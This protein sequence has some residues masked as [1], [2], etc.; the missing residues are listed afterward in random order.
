MQNPAR[1]RHYAILEAPAI[2]GLRSTGVER[3]PEVLLKC[4]LAERLR[5]RRVGAVAPDMPRCPDRDPEAN[6]LNARA[7]A[8]YTG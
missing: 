3:L 6:V 2:Y 4:G 7:I 8:K 5:A 1:E